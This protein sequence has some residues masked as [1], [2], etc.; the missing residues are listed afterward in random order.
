MVINE[1]NDKFCTCGCGQTVTMYRG[2]Y[3]KFISGH[4]SIGKVVSKGTGKKISLAKLGKKRKSF[5]AETKAKIGA[6]NIG[7]KLS[8]ETK[9]KIAIGN[10]RC[11]TDGYCDAWSD[12]EYKDDLLK[13]R[14]ERCGVEFEIKKDI[15]GREYPN[16]QLHHKDCNSE[17]CHPDNLQTLCIS[18]HATL[19]HKLRRHSEVEYV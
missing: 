7:K 15:N 12:K 6:A 16:L 14:C 3:R 2:K 17:N 11:R 4:N 8:D 1:K 19:H 9:Q 10:M 5:S 13:D 18:C